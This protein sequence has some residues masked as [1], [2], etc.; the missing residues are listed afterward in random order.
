MR[1]H[2][3]RGSGTGPGTHSPRRHLLTAAV[4][5]LLLGLALVQPVEAR[6][7]TAPPKP[8]KF[9]IA[10]GNTLAGM[11]QAALGNELDD[12]V[13]LGVTWIRIDLPW[14]LVQP[15]GPNSWSWGQYDAIFAAAK[16]RG[17]H[18]LPILDYTPAWARSSGCQ[19]FT[20]PPREIPQ[21]TAFAK[22]A[23]KRYAAPNVTTWEI[24]NEEN[25]PGFWPTPNARR[26]GHLLQRTAAVI[27]GTDPSSQVLMGGLAAVESTWS[28][29]SIGSRQFLAKVCRTGACDHIDGVAFHPY[30]YP[31]L[32]SQR[33]SFGTAWEKIGETT[34][35]LHSV[36]RRAGVGHLKIWATEFGAPTGGPGDASDGS[37]GSI[38]A[39]TDHVTEE[40]QAQIAADGVQT[41]AAAPNVA[42]LF[43]YSDQDD[44]LAQGKEAYFGLRRSDGSQKPAWQA[45]H[46]AVA[47]ADGAAAGAGS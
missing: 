3:S 12:A 20:C 39:T 6:A 33:T 26:Y 30:T 35:S 4:S 42:A 38:T 7:A 34:Y 45:F 18:V 23:V 2:I 21:F 32:A 43:W 19:R 9:G 40:R 1:G 22:A 29:G 14:T 25:Y 5:A 44:P 15:T 36:L 27:H 13:A 47:A 8:T 11:S 31:Y 41:A 24:W 28:P 37:P 17:L 46:D 16:A 10:Y